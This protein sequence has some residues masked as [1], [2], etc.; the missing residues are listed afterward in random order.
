MGIFRKRPET[1]QRINTDLVVL[2]WPEIRLFDPNISAHD[3]ETGAAW[4][5]EI[6]ETEVYAIERILDDPEVDGI[7]QVLVP[8]VGQMPGAPAN[9]MS[10]AFDFAQGW[11]VAEAESRAGRAEQGVIS[12]PSLLAL[13]LLRKMHGDDATIANA[14]LLESGY[15]GNR[16]RPEPQ[17]FASAVIA[18]A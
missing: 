15:L 14:K 9:L 10:L 1:T 17:A 6:A 12:S 13:S 18:Q 16:L 8:T 11:L 5:R 4:A 7:L 3:Y 2:C